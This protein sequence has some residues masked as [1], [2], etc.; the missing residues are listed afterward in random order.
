MK[1]ILVPCIKVGVVFGLFYYLNYKGLISWDSFQIGIKNYEYFLPGV[2]I[3]ILCSLLG[4]LRWQILLYAQE[5]RLPMVRTLQL[6]FIGNFFNIALPG[7][8]SGDLVKAFY[9]AKESPGDRAKAFGSILVDRIVGTSALVL[10]SVGA[11]WIQRDSLSGS[12]VIA[13]VRTF[14]WTAGVCV[15]FFYGYLFLMKENWDP[16]LKALNRLESF[17]SKFGSITRIYQGIR[18]YQSRKQAIFTVLFISILIHL[19]AGFACLEFSRAI[20][21]THLAAS[22]IYV[23][24]PLGMLVTAVPLLPGGV[25]TGHAAFGFF[26]QLIGSLKGADIFSLY[27][28]GQLFIGGLGGLIYLRFKAQLSHSA[29]E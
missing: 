19:G 12:P 28:L 17:S 11:L 26:F 21:E 8:V 29:K 6:H 13:G 7:A 3:L 10:V 2:G 9:I 15:F 1:N 5:I 16:I 20:Y 24:A 14:I 18:I 22:Q 25:G 23:V 27:V 4:V